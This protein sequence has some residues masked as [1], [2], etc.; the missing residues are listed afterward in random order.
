VTFLRALGGSSQR[1]VC[2]N[3]LGLSTAV[4]V[5]FSH[6]NLYLSE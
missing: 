6:A 4:R 1:V 2:D 3:D 5:V